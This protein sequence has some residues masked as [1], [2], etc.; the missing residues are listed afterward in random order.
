MNPFV[1]LLAVLVL[2]LFSAICSGINVGLVSL[3]EGDLR[4]KAKL[5]SAAAKR[6]LPFRKNLHYS[7]SVIEVNSKFIRNVT[8]NM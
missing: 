7:S 3:N 1:V 4:R 5:N 6:I 2:V 8:R